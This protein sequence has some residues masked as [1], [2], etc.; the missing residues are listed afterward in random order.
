MAGGAVGTGGGTGHTASPV[1]TFPDG[2]QILCPSVGE[3]F[4]AEQGVYALPLPHQKHTNNN[5]DDGQ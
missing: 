4:P 1:H 5:G 3:E 2:G